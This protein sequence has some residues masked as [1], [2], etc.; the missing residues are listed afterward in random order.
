MAKYKI[1]SVKTSYLAV[2]H[3]QISIL[4]NTD[5]ILGLILLWT[6]FFSNIIVYNPE[7]IFISSQNTVRFDI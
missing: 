4:Y 5:L 7:K 3:D 2:I 1:C 6:N